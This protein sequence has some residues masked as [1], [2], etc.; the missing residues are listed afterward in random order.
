VL[1]TGGKDEGDETAEYN[2]WLGYDH[3][4]VMGLNYTSVNAVQVA[5]F[6]PWS[7]DVEVDGNPILQFGTDVD[8][9]DDAEL[10]VF[11]FDVSR[12]LEYNFVVED[13]YDKNSAVF[14]GY[15][16][17]QFSLDPEQFFDQ[18]AEPDNAQFNIM[19]NGTT[20][21]TTTY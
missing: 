2:M 15:D 17:V 21:V 10:K 6:N 14:P 16:V 11:S 7:T 19:V 3:I 18:N 13:N 5:S 1:S 4:R 8:D 20:N 12:N 9:D